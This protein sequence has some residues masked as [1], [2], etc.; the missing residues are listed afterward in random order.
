MEWAEPEPADVPRY[1]HMQPA[2][3][4]GS[5]ERRI[6]TPDELAA[7]DSVPPDPPYRPGV[8]V[9]A[10][11]TAEQMQQSRK[12]GARRH[13]EVMAARRPAQEEEPTMQVVEATY[14]PPESPSNIPGDIPG[15]I[16]GTDLEDQVDAGPA[17]P[18]PADAPAGLTPASTD[19]IPDFGDPT[20]LPSPVAERARPLR[21]LAASAALAD[22]AW[23]RLQDAEAWRGIAY[24][25][26][27]RAR[28]GLVEWWGEAKDH[29]DL[30]PSRGSSFPSPAEVRH[31]Q[32]L[33]DGP[34]ASRDDGEL[35]PGPAMATIEDP[36]PAAL[37]VYNAERARIQA[38]E[39]AAYAEREAALGVQP[40]PTGGG[41][42][43]ACHS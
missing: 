19:P 10:G 12:N 43:R 36:D 38:E 41:S 33:E 6:A 28:E 21:E 37:E 7:R 15:D 27:V 34:R 3:D 31:E 16:P 4:P 24:A 17:Q 11:A 22:A 23:E 29:H 25:E 5:I 2:Y 42:G 14:D 30:S 32:L 1:G 9:G 18:G 35:L 8:V 40:E 13:V 20:S 26:W 39:D